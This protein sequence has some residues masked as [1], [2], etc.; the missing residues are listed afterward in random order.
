MPP[1]TI[2]PITPADAPFMREMVYA[3][4][5]AHEPLP[6]SIVDEPD[7]RHYHAHWGQPHDPGFVAADAHGTPI[8]AIWIRQLT[9]D[10]PGWGY[11]ADDVPEVGTLAVLAEWRGQGVGTALMH[12]MLDYADQH[13]ARVSLSCDPANPAMHLYRRFGFTYHGV[14]GT[15]HTLVR[16]R[17]NTDE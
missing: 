2:R 9:H 6:H 17:S 3:S 15:S 11:V 4:I 10:D 12:A 16:K 5:Y 1:F 13:Y 8:G 7:F 14:S